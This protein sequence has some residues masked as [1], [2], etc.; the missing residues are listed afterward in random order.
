M[1]M[2]VSSLSIYKREKRVRFGIC[3]LKDVIINNLKGNKN[4]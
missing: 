3:Y 4:Y 1:R 2:I